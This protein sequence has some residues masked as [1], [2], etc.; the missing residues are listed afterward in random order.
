MLVISAKSGQLGNRLL[1]FA[2]FIAFARENKFT[3]LNPAFEEYAEFFQS[4]AKDFL[5]CYP[6]PLLSIPG[7]KKIRQYYYNFNRS[8]VESGRFNTIDI[9]RDKPFNWS[10]SNIVEQLKPKSLNFFKGWLF[11]DGWFVDETANLR[12]HSDAIRAYFQPL[13]KYQE[14]IAKLISNIR[15]GT[16]I[17]IGVH[18]RQG[19]YRQHQDGRY[20]YQAEQ[21]LKVMESVQALFSDKQVTFL[22]C[23]NE[24]QEADFFQHLSYVYGN[25]HIIED[26]YALAECDYIIGPPSSYTMWASFYGERPLY[27][28]RDVNKAL[29]LKDF[30]HYYQWQGLFHY[31]DDWSK[32]FWEWTH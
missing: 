28:I 22:I 9:K 19:D 6:A 11:R 7:N 23:S 2:N 12:K 20:F 21:Y 29:E 3:V 14:N 25:N 31:N 27:M 16:D 4:T 10:R 30:V 8:L 5:C 15:N 18:I 17:L 13:K 26:M 32:S 24:K 1:L